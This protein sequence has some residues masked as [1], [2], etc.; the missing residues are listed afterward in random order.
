VAELTQEFRPD[1]V[2]VE[3]HVMGQF[4]PALHESTAPRVLVE[5]EPG[6]AAAAERRRH[7]PYRVLRHLDLR[8]WRRYERNVAR[9]VDVVV[10]LTER[11]RRAVAALAEDISTVVIPLGVELPET[12]LDPL[13]TSDELLF[14]ANYL[15]SPNVDAAV[16]LA[17]DIFPS[18]RARH[19]GA[20]LRL[21]GPGMPPVVRALAGNGVIVMGKVTSVSPYLRDAAVI[22]VPLRH[23]GGMRVKV[24]E[25]LAYG[26]AVVASP[27]AVEGMDVASHQQLVVAR[28]DTEFADAVSDLLSQPERR[29][30]LALA[31]RAWAVQS[32]G[33]D[34]AVG[35]YETLYSSLL[36]KSVSRDA[37]PSVRSA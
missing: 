24:L 4:L 10:V 5:H 16:R 35:A 36:S 13:G 20:T 11:D 3:Y 31:A 1:I 8:A 28:T 22:V 2:Q 7:A 21:I 33:W 23:G 19:P 30:E 27:L 34:G 18:V 25:S 14:F 17:R 9:G 6:A 29:R 37:L 15:H 32:G 12:P 26:K